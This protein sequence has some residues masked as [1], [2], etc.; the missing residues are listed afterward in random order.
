[1][2]LATAPLFDADQHY[3]VLLLVSE[4]SAFVSGSWGL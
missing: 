4:R 2:D 1:M 3:R